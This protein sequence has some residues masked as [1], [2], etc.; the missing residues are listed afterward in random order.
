MI[1][2]HGARRDHRVAALFERVSEEKFKLSSL[3]ASKRQPRE[4]I[5]FDPQMGTTEV[6]R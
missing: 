4:V 3:V 1:G 2:L 6:L 5:A